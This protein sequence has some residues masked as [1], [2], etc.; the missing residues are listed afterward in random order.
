MY[1]LRESWR[2]SSSRTPSQHVVFMDMVVFRLTDSR[3]TSRVS[4]PPRRRPRVVCLEI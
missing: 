2:D 1:M 3:P 4:G